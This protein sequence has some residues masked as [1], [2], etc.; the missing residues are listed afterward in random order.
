M[1]DGGGRGVYS[2]TATVGVIRP[3]VR[4]I[5]MSQF[6]RL[7]LLGSVSVGLSFSFMQMRPI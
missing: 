7:S 5:D 1:S 3:S 2:A 6:S 4:K